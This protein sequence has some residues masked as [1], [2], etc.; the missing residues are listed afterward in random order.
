M[1]WKFGWRG[2]L[3]AIGLVSV[4]PDGLFAQLPSFHRTEGKVEVQFADQ[5]FTTLRT[6]DYSKPVLYPVLAPGQIPMTRGWPIEELPGEAHD[7][8]HHKS[9]WFA[10]GDVN[11][12]DFWADQ[13]RIVTET[14]ELDE[15]HGS[16]RLRH[17]W[18]QN[19]QRLASDWTLLRFGGDSRTRWIDWDVTVR[20][21]TAELVWGDTKEGTFAVRTHPDLQLT[22]NPAQGVSEVFGQ[23]LNSAGDRDKTVWGR[24]AEWVYYFGPVD[25]QPAGLMIMDHPQNLRHPTPWHARD[26]G[27]VAANPFGLHEFLGE[28]KGAGSVS[29]KAGDS[30]RLVYRLL[31]HSGIG[32][33]ADRQAWFR[34]FAE[35]PLPGAP[36]GR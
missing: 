33:E 4:S 15:A 27:L 31:V 24:R 29:L 1:N 8:P 3:V 30:L 18:F 14:I 2:T 12:A 19:E 11:G 20:A 7:H 13:D 6:G 17:R 21:E 26:Y 32:A 22:A 23:A 28:P 16:L 35:T 9:V 25:G 5:P 34:S 10:H 36:E